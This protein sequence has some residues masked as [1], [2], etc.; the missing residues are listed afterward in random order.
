[1]HQPEE[2]KDAHLSDAWEKE[3]RD[4]N[5][6]GLLSIEGAGRSDFEGK[7]KSLKG[8]EAGR[9][10]LLRRKSIWAVV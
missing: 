9:S 6:G 1:M 2:K 4:E 7:K 8:K 5:N 3:G 10:T